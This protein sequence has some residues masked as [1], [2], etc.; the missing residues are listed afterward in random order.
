MR[1]YLD[2]NDQLLRQ[3]RRLYLQ[4]PLDLR[5]DKLMLPASEL[6]FEAIEFISMLKIEAEFKMATGETNNN[7]KSPEPIVIM[8]IRN[9]NA[10]PTHNIKNLGPAGNLPASNGL[11]PHNQQAPFARLAPRQA[12]LP[13]SRHTFP[14][15]SENDNRI[16]WCFDILSTL[17]SD[18]YCFF[19]P[20]F[21]TAG[22]GEIEILGLSTLLN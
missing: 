9:E 16:R 17:Y 11:K 13:A 1:I 19:Y 22:M 10:L 15:R 12:Q 6:V 3:L 2:E 14:V 5:S 4:L 20:T 8:P 18:Y 21:C 7:K